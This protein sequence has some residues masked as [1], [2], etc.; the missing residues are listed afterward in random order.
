MNSY[1]TELSYLWLEIANPIR[2]FG[3]TPPNASSKPAFLFLW[4]FYL[5]ISLPFQ[6]QTLFS[7]P[8]SQFPKAF[9][10]VRS[11]LA[12]LYP[13]IFST[14][15]ILTINSL[16]IFLISASENEELS[17]LSPSCYFL[18]A[19]H[20]SFSSWIS[21]SFSLFISYNSKNVCFVD[22]ALSSNTSMVL[23]SSLLNFSALSNFAYI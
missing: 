6:F 15:I 12:Q 7:K 1:M 11:Q 17:Y 21:Y 10:L 19:S 5:T 14:K 16:L 18:R 23:F 20:L 13:K 9:P 22:S 4:F 3:L 8:Y 2:S